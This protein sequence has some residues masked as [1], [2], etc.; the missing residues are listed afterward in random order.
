MHRIAATTTRI[1]AA[2]S[3]GALSLSWTL[4]QAGDKVR[5]DGEKAARQLVEKFVSGWNTHDMKVLG[6][7]FSDDAEFINVVGMHWRGKDAIIKAHA[8]Y[9][10]TLF[11]D[12]K[13]VTDEVSFRPLGPDHGIAVWVCTQ[14]KFTT[15]GG[16]VVPRHQNRLTLVLARDQKA[17]WQ[18]VHAQNT[19]IDAQAVQFDPVNKK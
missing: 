19:P 6:S 4:A 10:E 15:P 11:K 5:D 7:I 16:A 14:D 18:V 13:L 17:G 12:C 2:L 3:V 1:L 9:H 8:A